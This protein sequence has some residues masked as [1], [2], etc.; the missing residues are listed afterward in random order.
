MRFAASCVSSVG[1]GNYRGYRHEFNSNFII[2]LTV[3]RLRLV[4]GNQAGV[5]ISETIAET[6]PVIREP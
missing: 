3:S 5:A 6:M 2:L 1:V 4:L